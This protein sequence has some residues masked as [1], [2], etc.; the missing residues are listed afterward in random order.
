MVTEAGAELEGPSGRP[1]YDDLL[2]KPTSDAQAAGHT[3]ASAAYKQ[4][5]DRFKLAT[6]AFDR[7]YAHI[8][9]QRLMLM[10]PPLLTKV[11]QKWPGIKLANILTLPENDEVLVVGTVYKDMK[12]KPSILDEYVKD[13][14]A[15][16]LVGRTKFVGADDSIILEDESARMKLRGEGLPVGQ[17]VTGVVMAVK[18]VAAPGGDFQ[19]N[20]FCFANMAPQ[21]PLPS[22]S[23]DK[24]VALVSGL[25]VGDDAGDPLKLS[26]LVDYLVGSLASDEE[27]MRVSKIVRV[28]VAGGLLKS[29]EG[30]LQATTHKQP[31]QQAAALAPIREVDMCLSELA[32]AVPVEVMPGNNDPANHSLPQQPLHRCLFPLASSF[33]SFNRVTNP[34]EFE[35][36][37]I[38][39]LGTSG[40]NL[41]DI[42]KYSVEENRLT[43]LQRVL[44]WGHLVPTAPDTLTC[45]PLSDSDP[46][47]LQSAPHVFFVGNQPAYSSQMVTGPEG[48]KVLLISLPRFSSSGTLILV[49]LKTL[50]VHPIQFDADISA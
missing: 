1:K 3:R 48:Q 41:D 31:C 11:R 20:A 28:V 45:Y 9:F 25:G 16:Q 38:S 43:L 18:G 5:G 46:F 19:V 47:I 2:S 26:L 33:T 17:L 4:K 40:Q 32:G 7:Q 44:E 24:Y 8:Y 39:F 14:G 42:Y 37:G 12:L 21:A 22:L 23:E 29:T 35:V 50:A 13:R 10:K 49:N 34:H 27:Q 6:Q 30:L 36:D 15:S